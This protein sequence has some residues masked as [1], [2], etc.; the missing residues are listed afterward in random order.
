ML[1]HGMPRS[2]AVEVAIARWVE[3]LGNV[4]DRIQHCN[5]RIDRPHQHE[6][7]SRFQIRIE[8]GIPG[9]EIVV[10]HHGAD[11]DVYVALSEAFTSARRR[12]IDRAQI[13]RGD[14]KHHAG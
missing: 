9:E 12:L 7:T 5:V 2:E 6:R 11:A 13:R 14:V 1:F 3:R 8:L 10:S 4:F